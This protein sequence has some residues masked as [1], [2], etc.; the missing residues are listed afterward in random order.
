MSDV[1]M[2][3]LEQTLAE[4]RARRVVAVLRA[5][6]AELAEKAIDAIVAGG[7][8]CIEIAFTTPDATTAIARA[9]RRYGASIVI[10]AGTVVT[11][12]HARDAVSA[13]ADFLVSPGT[14]PA[15]A[16]AMLD[17][18]A[19]VMTGALSPTEVL[20]AVSCGAHIVKVF[21]ASLGGPA[22][23]KA[24]RGPFPDLA[25]MPTGGV[26]VNNVMEWFDA[27]A[28]A[29]GAGGELCPN[30]TMLAGRWD[31]VTANAAA[32]IKAANARA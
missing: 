21:P 12:A 5:P 1:L 10:G 7:V 30:A 3:D 9:V 28:V 2:Y 32:L 6:T 17:T 4:I 16:A 13:G 25:F 8:T 14:I 18:G 22:Y 19:A 15:L 31:D 29:V 11:P 24:L 20:T 27:G 23:L 26:N